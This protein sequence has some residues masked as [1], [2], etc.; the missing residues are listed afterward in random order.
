[1]FHFLFPSLMKNKRIKE[2]KLWWLNE[3]K[4]S[5]TTT[6][7]FLFPSLIKNKYITEK[8]KTVVIE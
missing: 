6:L 3:N 2:R 8:K 1:M 7:H 4:N 5:I